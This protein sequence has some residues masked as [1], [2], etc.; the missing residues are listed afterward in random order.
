MI[1]EGLGA[2]LAEPE[3]LLHLSGVSLG[4][5]LL[6]RSADGSLLERVGGRSLGADALEYRDIGLSGNL[7]RLADLHLDMSD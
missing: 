7:E 6:H 4:D 3:H 5:R 2:V 1:V